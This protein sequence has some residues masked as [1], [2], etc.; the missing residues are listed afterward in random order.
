MR[1]ESINKC[2]KVKNNAER[3]MVRLQAEV[4]QI[5]K[6]GKRTPNGF[7]YKKDVDTITSICQRYLAEEKQNNIRNIY[8]Y[9][10]DTLRIEYFVNVMSP[11]GKEKTKSDSIYFKWHSDSFDLQYRPT[12]RTEDPYDVF[13][14]EN[15]FKN[16]KKEIEEMEKKLKQIQRDNLLNQYGDFAGEY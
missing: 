14:A 6:Y 15:E 13:Y 4:Q 5:L 10:D 9:D 2:M 12:L 1:A 3:V 16:L 8:F 7:L 11:S